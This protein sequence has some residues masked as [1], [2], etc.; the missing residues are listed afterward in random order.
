MG[1]VFWGLVGSPEFAALLVAAIAAVAGYVA[2]WV[3]AQ[4]LKRVDESDRKLIEDRARKAVIFAE[5]MYKLATGEDLDAV[6]QA[7]LA[8]ASAR[9][10]DWLRAMG[11]KLTAAQIEAEIE[12]AV[13]TN[14]GE[15]P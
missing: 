5:Q 11:I 3:R 14:L 8:E 15:K 1:E 12:Y 2:K 10:D 13:A 6:R 9:L 7:K 4:W